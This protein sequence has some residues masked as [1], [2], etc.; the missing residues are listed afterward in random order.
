VSAF[1][2]KPVRLVVPYRVGGSSDVVARLLSVRLAELWGQPVT[3]DNVP[4]TAS[5]YGTHS[6]ANAQPDGHTLLVGNSALA[7][8]EALS[9]NLP[10]H[11]LRDFAPISLAARQQVALVVNAGA[12][13][14]SFTQLRDA[15][16]AKPGQLSYGSAGPGAVGHLAGELLKHVTATNITHVAY[17]GN[18][19][20]LR[21]LIANHI[22]YAMIGLPS[23][24]RHVTA[25]RLRVLAVAGSARAEALP[26][27]PTIGESVPGY[28]V[29]NWIGILAPYGATVTLVREINAHLVRVINKPDIKEL[30]SGLGYE[31]LSSTPGEFHYRLAADI[32]RYSRIVAAAGISLQ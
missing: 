8:N 1:P 16:R 23:A 27:V 4:G 21:E 19:Q 10:Y 28:E 7:I 32:E 31:P 12:P 6:V 3:V 13:F 14:Y 25:G 22:T 20:A 18:R 9:R 11:A 2:D 29:N 15:A 24:M 17:S 26:E 30:L 5:I